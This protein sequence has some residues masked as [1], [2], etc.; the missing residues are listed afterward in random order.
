MGR[1]RYYVTL[2]KEVI[3]ALHIVTGEENGSRLHALDM[4]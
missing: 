1:F 2:W 3:G 4:H